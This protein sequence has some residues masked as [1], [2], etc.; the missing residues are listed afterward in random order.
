[1]KKA[2]CI[3]LFYCLL[4]L[5]SFIN[6][7]NSHSPSPF[8]YLLTKFISSHTISQISISGYRKNIF[9]KYFLEIV[10]KRLDIFLGGIINV[11]FFVEGSG[12]F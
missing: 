10:K 3:G 1:M 11:K 2:L 12:A 8:Y 5:S 6:T 9:P 4:S 7:I